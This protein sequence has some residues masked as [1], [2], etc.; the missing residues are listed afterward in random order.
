MIITHNG[1]DVTKNIG[2]TTTD[3][4]NVTIN[5]QALSKVL[6]AISKYRPYIDIRKRENTVRF[7][8]DAYIFYALSKDSYF[9]TAYRRLVKWS[10][11]SDLKTKKQFKPKVPAM[12]AGDDEYEYVDT[13]IHSFISA[14]DAEYIGGEFKLRLKYIKVK[15]NATADIVIEVVNVNEPRAKSAS[16]VK[17]TTLVTLLAQKLNLPGATEA[18]LKKV[19]A[20]IPADKYLNTET[21][22]LNTIT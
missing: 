19:L 13:Y 1:T 10:V 21:W 12:K 8:N 22:R 4:R 15:E 6:L 20:S 3:V 7:E 17:P 5:G 16:P 2:Y 9:E 11:G 14:Q 18:A